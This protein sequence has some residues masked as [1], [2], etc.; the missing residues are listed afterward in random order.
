[1]WSNVTAKLVEPRGLASAL[2]LSPDENMPGDIVFRRLVLCFLV[3]KDLLQLA[4]TCK[5]TKDSI[6]HMLSR[7]VLPSLASRFFKIN[8]FVPPAKCSALQMYGQ[9]PNEEVALFAPDGVDGKPWYGTA[10]FVGDSFRFSPLPEL[11]K[12]IESKTLFHHRNVVLL[13]TKLIF[14]VEGCELLTFDVFS[15][16]S[17]LIYKCTER[18]CYQWDDYERYIDPSCAPAVFGVRLFGIGGNTALGK[19]TYSH[20]SPL[21]RCF[22]FSPQIEITEIISAAV[23]DE[24]EDDGNDEDVD[25]SDEEV[26][27]PEKEEP[28]SPYVACDS[29]NQ[30]K[31]DVIWTE[32]KGKLYALG[33]S[34]SING[35]NIPERPEFFDGETWTLMPGR[36]HGLMRQVVAALSTPAG[37]LLVMDGDSNFDGWYY[38]TIHGLPQNDPAN[39]IEDTSAA[40]IQVLDETGKWTRTTTLFDD[41]SN[42]VCAAFAKGTRIYF[43]YRLR[44]AKTDACKWDFFDMESEERGSDTIDESERLTPCSGWPQVCVLNHASLAEM[45]TGMVV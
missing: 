16:K 45:M 28:L 24:V 40:F 42:E 29:L 21:Q 25:S 4:C 6:E 1:M 19:D 20:D 10:K 15:R 27:E 13:G 3:P 9:V 33:N 23:S 34:Q 37:L 17:A 18:Y 14:W 7:V 36:I 44:N 22:K 2:S 26:D 35:E 31:E 43:F 41:A 12:L 11:S 39:E 30:P 32:H 5:R 38:E 8:N